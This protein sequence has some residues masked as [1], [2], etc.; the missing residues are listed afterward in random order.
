M[1]Y[2]VGNTGRVVVARMEDGDQVYSCIEKMCIA[3]NINSAVF[4]I[5]GANKNVEVVTGSH[6]YA[7]RPVEVIVEKL[8]SVQEILGT[9]TIFPDSNNN[10]K[11]H[12]HASLG[13]DS[14]T[15]TGC[16]RINLDCWLINEVVVMEITNISAKRLKNETG[17]ELLGNISLGLSKTKLN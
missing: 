7:A 2:E 10:P 8:N 11:I 12:M 1:K 5:I 6:N 15:V 9:G 14:E 17:F 16:P 4:W 13:H 3:E